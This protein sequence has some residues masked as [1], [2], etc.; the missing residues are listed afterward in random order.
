[1]STNGRKRVDPFHAANN[2]HPELFY[3]ARV[4]FV[5]FVFIRFSRLKR[6]FGFK[7]DI[8]IKKPQRCR[9]RGSGGKRKRCPRKAEPGKNEMTACGGCRSG[10]LYGNGRRNCRLW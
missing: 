4:H 2:P 5:D 7:Q 10:W 9:K 6:H 8:W 1:M 3:P